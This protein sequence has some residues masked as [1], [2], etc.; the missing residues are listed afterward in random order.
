ME[1]FKPKTEQCIPQPS[2]KSLDEEK[3]LIMED[4]YKKHIE[5]VENG[6]KKITLDD[7]KELKEMG[8]TTEEFLDFLCRK[9]GLLLHGSV[10]EIS[11]NKLNRIRGKF[12][13]PIKRL[14]Q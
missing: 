6:V 13:L 5:S 3:K 1:K 14:S 2:E 11:D 9:K 12:L 8:I 4:F 7:L 10:H